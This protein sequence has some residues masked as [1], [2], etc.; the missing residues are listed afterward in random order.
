MAT[1]APGPRL[2]GREEELR[3]LGDAFDRAA[4]GHLTAVIVEGEAGIGKT[5][6]LADALDDARARGFEVVTGR[7]RELER[8]RPFGL[9]ADGFGCVR[10]SPDP[11]RAAIAALLATQRGDRGP[12]TVSSDPGLQFQAVDAFVDLAEELALHGPLVLAVDDLQWADPSSLLTLAALARRLPDSPVA[13][14]GCLRPL[15]R[16]DELERALEALDAGGARRLTLG[17]LGEEAVVELVAEAVAA[18]PGRKLIAEVAAAGG[19]PL[20]VTE[21]VGALLQEGAIQTVNGRAEVAEMVLPPTLRLTILRR[22]SFLPEQA[23][24]GLR[25]ASVLGSSFSL[26]ELSTTTARSVLELSSVLA[27]A[28]RARILEDDGD[29]LRF[30]HDLI[31]EAIYLDLPASVRLAL[32]REAGR[33]LAASGAAALRVAEHLARGAEVGDAEAIAWLTTAARE[34]A[35]KS[36]TIAADLL[37][38]AVGLSEP[39]DPGRDRLLAERAS[40]LVWAG[41][42]ADAE[43]TCRVLLDRDHDPSLQ[44][45]ARICLGW[46]MVAEGRMRDALRQLERVH[47][48]P[49]AGDQARATA[50]GWA[51]MAHLS[52][53]ELDGAAAAAEQARPAAAAAGDHATTS[54]ALTCLAV[55]HELRGDLRQAVRVIDEAA[56]RADQSPGR[57]GHRYPLHVTRGHILLELDRPDDARHTLETGR[58]ISEELGVR[59]AVTSYQVFLAVERFVAGAWDDAVAEF[60]AALELVAETGERY[61]LVL[62]HSVMSLMALRR[63]DLQHA[64]AAAADAARELAAGGPRYR[65][66]WALWA[67]A[68]LLEAGGDVP[69]AFATLDGCWDLCARSGLA[70]EYPALGADLVRL[71]LAA[72]EE[73]RAAQVAAAVAEVAARNDVPSL[74]G[75]ALRC[76]GLVERDPAV[77]RSAVEAYAQ[78][79]RPLELALTAEDAGRGFA[80]RGDAAA[81]APLLHQALAAYERLD[82]AREAARAEAILRELGIRRGRRGA[83]RRPQLGWDSLTPTEHRVVDLVVEGLSNPQIGEC[84]FVSRRTVQT[85]LAHVFTKL[86]ISARAQLAAE[87]MRQRQAPR[88]S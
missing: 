52:L 74:A 32:H 87:A 62:G 8:T 39:A 67:R 11:R 42:L 50:W 38:R 73:G 60:E 82:A 9:L 31:H 20:F 21:L 77:L 65:S 59:W 86:G 13:L 23:L 27:E 10:S 28:L 83:R 84:L 64:E 44:A 58:R 41:R 66:H 2:R 63:G 7:A 5:R 47:Q 85:H 46:I 45:Q 56:R 69:G 26:V 14:V 15:P 33:R 16:A 71:A 19:N 17:Q 6:L 81:A 49:A 76:Q 51:S 3:A 34:A 75:A 61:S 79:P 48:S 18:E 43:A 70:I 35:P 88:D 36:P 37:E 53:G 30:R 68:L 24:E 72:G 22:L 57:Q 55:V 12:L 80:R 54:L 40:T 4:S 1:P 29:R 25:A 78:G